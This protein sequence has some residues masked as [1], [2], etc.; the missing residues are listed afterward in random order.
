MGAARRADWQDIKQQICSQIDI[1][2]EYMQFP[3]FRPDGRPRSSGWLACYSLSREERNASAAI[4]VETGVYVDSV[5]GENLNFFDA[6]LRY[7]GNPALTSFEDCLKHYADKAGVKL[8][9]FTAA[10]RPE[11]K[12]EFQPWG[13]GNLR[14]ARKWCETKRGVSLESVILAGGRIARYPC[15]S[16]KGKRILGENKC[17]VFPAYGPRLTSDEPV[18]HVAFNV[19]GGDV[20][21]PPAKQGGEK[22]RER[23]VS[24]GPTTET[25]MNRSGL[26]CNREAVEVVIKTGGPSDMLAAMRIFDDPSQRVIVTTNAS[27]EGGHVGAWVYSA[28]PNAIWL[29][30]HDRDETGFLG[31]LRWLARGA[32]SHANCAAVALPYAIAAKHGKDFRDFLAAAAAAAAKS[33][34]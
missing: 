25:L 1:L 6:V 15:W 30:I 4:N 20:T 10:D 27:G 17:I 23:F 22:R 11:N 7:G 21:L 26:E 2:Q 32:A 5:S 24:V 34:G 29:I 9:K 19:T 31:Q 16:K 33:A 3:E 28:F 18:A 14:Q 8:G 13:A 12:L